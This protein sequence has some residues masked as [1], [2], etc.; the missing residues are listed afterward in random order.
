MKTIKDVFLSFR[1]SLAGVYDTLETE[2][3][4][5]LVLEEIT[6]ISRAKLKAFP[7]D[8]IP[9]EASEKIEGILIELKTGKP[10]QYILGHTEFYGLNFLVNPATLIPRPETEELVEWILQSK[11]L[12]PNSQKPV[13]VLDIG[14]GSGCIAISL[15]KNLPD[16]VVTAIDISAD[17]LHTAKQNAVINGAEVTFIEQDILE[18]RE[19][20]S[21][22]KNFDIIVSNPPYVTLQDKLLMHKNVT[23]FEP[24]S[25]LFV[26]E[27]NP[28]IFYEAI[29]DFAIQHLSKNGL[30][31]LEINENFG[32]ETIELLSD[33]YFINIEL[34]KDMSGRDRMIKAVKA[35]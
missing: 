6:G 22:S 13:Y 27:H 15:K 10:V 3:I 2:V 1:Q 9:G 12:V 4:A 11:K 7:E 29:A 30:L 21:E 16:A 18:S 25:A 26:P 28:L 17:A 24:H 8:T 20:K 23:G 34:R 33:K 31:F 14:T 35:S 5:L 32:K 19:L